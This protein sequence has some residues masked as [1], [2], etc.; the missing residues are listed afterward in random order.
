MPVKIVRKCSC[1]KTPNTNKINCPLNDKAAKP[2]KKTHILANKLTVCLSSKKQMKTSKKQMKTSKKQMK[3]SK[4]TSTVSN[5]IPGKTITLNDKVILIED[6]QLFKYNVSGSGTKSNDV[7]NKKRENLMVYLF[8]MTANDAFF[9]DQKWGNMWA[10]YYSKIT[11][12]KDN[13]LLK[14]DKKYISVKLKAGS[15]NYD[16][17]GT[18][19]N[20]VSDTNKIKLKLEYKHQGGF[21]KLPQIYQKDNIGLPLFEPA[22]WLY[23]YD[24]IPSILSNFGIS[25]NMKLH[26]LP[27]EIETYR[28]II[29]FA[30]HPKK[31]S[32]EE[33]Y[34]DSWKE[35]CRSKSQT[36]HH[37]ASNLI[38][39]LRTLSGTQGDVL[40]KLVEKNLNDYWGL[41][42]ANLNSG[43]LSTIETHIRMKQGIGS[44]A[45]TSSSKIFIFYSYKS[46]DWDFQDI[47][48]ID[49]LLL[50]KDVA[51]SKI[52]LKRSNTHLIIPTL[53]GNHLDFLLRWKNR[54][55][56]CLPAWQISLKINKHNE[57]KLIEF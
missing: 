15:S 24:C 25:V 13:L 37:H 56:V 35:W 40:D 20:S 11:N 28:K 41:V 19:Y 44:G 27:E 50:D 47:T 51:K 53:A 54:K 29:K 14:H 1:C 5:K 55:G 23:F 22:Y 43:I 49:S 38:I 12:H 30:P 57:K 33:G 21:D 7:L 48:T 31:K 32:S 10:E 34:E 52:V 17:E 3:T 9:S 2:N 16:F 18:L 6:I 26:S 46:D 8:N 45:D 4:K 39:T 42:H 36:K